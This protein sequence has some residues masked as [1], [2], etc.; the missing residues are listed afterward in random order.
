MFGWGYSADGRIGKVGESLQVSP[1]DAEANM[2]VD[3]QQST[4]IDL[5][6]AEKLVAESM[7]NEKHMPIIWEPCLVEELQGLRVEDIAC[8]LD[9]S[10]VLCCEYQPTASIIIFFG[11]VIKTL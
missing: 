9:H 6:F 3:G 5:E 2:L 11:K 4:S 10:L 8:W 1:L 7:E